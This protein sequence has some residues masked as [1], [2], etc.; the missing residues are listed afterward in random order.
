MTTK[1]TIRNISGTTV[2]VGHLFLISSIVYKWDSIDKL[3]ELG[4][5]LLPVTTYAL[6]SV[7]RF[8]S[9]N[10]LY[11]D[12]A[13]RALFLFSLVSVG[14]PGFVFAAN[15]V[16]IMAVDTNLLGAG[17]TVDQGREMIT[18]LETALGAGYATIVEGLF[19]TVNKDKEGAVTLQDREK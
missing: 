2:F 4:A 19:S 3:V 6:A 11:S 1:R 16:A 7:I 10:K 14:L 9:S 18:W 13:D 15:V 5:P 12:D 8:S 17:F